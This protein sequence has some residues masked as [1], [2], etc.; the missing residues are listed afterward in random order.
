MSS[1]HIIQFAVRCSVTTPTT[2]ISSLDGISS[3]K[4]THSHQTQLPQPHYRLNTKQRNRKLWFRQRVWALISSH[5]RRSSWS[6]IFCLHSTIQWMKYCA[7]IL[8]SAYSLAATMCRWFYWKLYYKALWCYFKIQF[9]KGGT[10]ECEYGTFHNFIAVH[11]PHIGMPLD[12]VYQTP[13]LGGIAR[14]FA[15]ILY[16]LFRALRTRLPFLIAVS[17]TGTISHLCAHLPLFKC[18]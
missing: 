18:P 17:R 7:S 13:V 3:L 1:S 11:S 12:V 5:F 14:T 2:L 4:S 15:F 6:M 10:W 16:H 8:L 9:I